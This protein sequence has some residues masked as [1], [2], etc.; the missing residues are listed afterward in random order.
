MSTQRF[1]VGGEF[2]PQGVT[3]GNGR[4]GDGSRAVEGELPGFLPGVREVPV[5][6]LRF[7]VRGGAGGAAVGRCAGAASSGGVAGMLIPGGSCAAVRGCR[8]HAP[9]ASLAA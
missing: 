6:R 2:P 9:E 4:G 5:R 7:L 8:C 3:K 1:H